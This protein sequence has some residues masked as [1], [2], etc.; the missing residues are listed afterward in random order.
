MYL[1]TECAISKTKLEP[2]GGEPRERRTRR[3]QA[4]LLQQ[5]LVAVVCFG[6]LCSSSHTTKT[7]LSS[8][9][10]LHPVRLFSSC[11]S[12]VCA[13]RECVAFCCE[14]AT[15][16]KWHGFQPICIVES[17]SAVRCLQR[18]SDC[19]KVN[20]VSVA[21]RGADAVDSLLRGTAVWA[22]RVKQSVQWTN[23]SQS[24]RGGLRCANA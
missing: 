8:L 5:Q 1:C 16:A 21:P 4:P 9:Q 2:Q 11:L 14:A 24:E 13:V 20:R 19:Y 22:R 15:Q 12:L 17:L 7:A 10:L 18:T 3:T 23:C 6:S